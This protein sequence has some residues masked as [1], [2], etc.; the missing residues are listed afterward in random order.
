MNLAMLQLLPGE[1][2]FSCSQ[3]MLVY[4]AYMIMNSKSEK[5]D[6]NTINGCYD[7]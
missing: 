3:T 4:S 6:L 7:Y 1:V 5:Q 2:A